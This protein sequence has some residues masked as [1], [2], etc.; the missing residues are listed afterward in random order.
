MNNNFQKSRVWNNRLNTRF[1]KIKK[2]ENKKSTKSILKLLL[3]V[4]LFFVISLFIIFIV[5]YNKYLKKLSIEELKD[6]QISESSILY[7]KD[8]KE[9]Y[10]F[11]I[12]NRTY[13]DYNEISKNIINAL[14]AWE[15][16]RYWENPWV[17][18]VWLMR[19]W[20][21]SILWWSKIAWTS[22]LTQQLI[23][24]TIIEN[25]SSN[26]TFAEWIDRKIK[27]IFLSYQL[28][29]SLSKEKII[30][31]YLNKIEFWHNS[32]GIE[33]ATKKFF[34]KRAKD[35]NIFEASI[36]ASLPKWP[37]SYS[38]YNNQWKLVWYLILNKNL[39]DNEKETKKLVSSEDVESEKEL[40]D[41]LKN[42]IKNLKWKWIDWSD[43]YVICNVDKNKIKSKEFDVDNKWCV[44]LPYSRLQNF[45]SDIEIKSWD[46][47]I[48]Y[49]PW[50]KDYILQRMIEDKYITFE[51]YKDAVIEWFGYKFNKVKEKITAPH[52]V[53][54]IKEYLWKKYW[55]EW[56]SRWWLKIYT[57]LDL[58]AQK[59][60]EEIIKK[61]V[62]KNS[63]K[64][65]AKNSSLIAIDNKTWGIVAMV[66]SVDYFSDDWKWQVNIVTSK[67]QPGSSFKPF[68]YSLAMAQNEIWTKTPVYDLETTFPWKYEPKNFDWKFM[69]KI[70]ISTALNH[71]RNIPAV[72]MFYMTKWVK[73][74]VDFM[75]K[76]W[77]T[78]LDYNEK[79]WAS[80]SLWTWEM[81]PLDLAKAY[82]VFANMWEKVEI[83]PILKIVDSKWNIVEEK[84]LKKEKVMPSWQA[85]LINE[86]LSDTSTRPSWW[87]NYL[88]IWRDAAA[89]TWT[90][91]KPI[92][93]WTKVTQYPANLWTVWY[94][95]QITTVVWSWN[96]DWETLKY[97]WNWLEASWPIWRDFM[98]FYHNWKKSETWQR[99]TDV[100][101][102]TISEISWYLPNPEK[103]S[104]D[105]LVS[106]FFMNTPKKI[107]NSYSVIEYDALCNWKITEETPIAARKKSIILDLH[108]LKPDNQA[109]EGPVKR[110]AKSERAI[111]RY[112]ATWEAVNIKNEICKR[113]NLSKDIIIKSNISTEKKYNV[114]LVPIELAFKSSSAIVKI[115]ILINWELL[116]TIDI[117]KKNSDWLRESLLIDQKYLNSKV[118]I[119][120]RAINEEYFSWSE[121]K[122]INIWEVDSSQET[123]IP[124]TQ[125]DKN[126]VEN[127][128]IIN[129]SNPKNSSVKIYEEDYFNLR[130]SISPKEKLS[131]VNILLDDINY[132]SLWNSWDYVLAINKEDKIKKWI[133]NLKIQAI[134]SNWKIKEKILQIEIL[135]K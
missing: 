10:K 36:L 122:E 83:A 14:V 127:D 29:K 4:F 33:E 76:L 49:Y 46:K 78:S 111:E 31:L 56:I 51:E 28:T 5:I 128:L 88:S 9:L 89:K 69:W 98:K 39:E 22:T 135:S 30:E 75:H 65:N 63:S 19:A 96:T 20:M 43:K 21:R 79:Y 42:E 1:K 126:E 16:Q 13:V 26:E 114:W 3:Y 52:F 55:E 66:W 2:I 125:N 129:I 86:I 94:T 74:I 34:N 133:T 48:I 54:Y 100:K 71:S 130:F 110:W 119:E 82:T 45:I 41:K 73:D 35:A 104:N 60:A 123:E 87:N 103:E 132:K 101:N 15:D 12:E 58:E 115:E 70:N 108:S 53:F 85:F 109:W 118:K 37:T 113:T 62:E 84:S 105:F 117:N 59:K 50:R 25:R 99:P 77:A 90:S 107:D 81:T 7:D 121:I 112:W 124:K 18:I 92:K 11:Y 72:K 57:T 102:V 64:F 24:N 120:L 40:V 97:S 80:I 68:V 44:V 95:P 23:R 131:N 93:E 134:D 67:L 38:P 106:S 32:F 47:S 8:W 27:E 61:Q 116:K 17:D 6:Y 91:T